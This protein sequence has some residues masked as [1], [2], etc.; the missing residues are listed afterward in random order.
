ML[1]K[2]N[3]HRGLWRRRRGLGCLALWGVLLNVEPVFAAGGLKVAY[4]AIK[5]VDYHDQL[6]IRAPLVAATETMV[7]HQLR[8]APEQGE[9]PHR[10]LV[11]VEFSSDVD[12]VDLAY[13]RKADVAA[14]SFF[15]GTDNRNTSIGP[16]TVYHL[17]K[18]LYKDYPAGDAPPS[19]RSR[20]YYFYFNV[21][22]RPSPKSKPPEPGYDLEHSPQDICFYLTAAG[23]WWFNLKSNVV[24]IPRDAIARAFGPEAAPAS[25]GQRNVSG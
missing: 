20:E 25:P 22:R 15:C 19:P 8:T 10:Q 23:S 14:W 9:R 2:V 3:D 16:P 1:I 12:L 6:D 21:A 11:R 7:G 24:T 5:V 18:P 4:S 17:G 13:K